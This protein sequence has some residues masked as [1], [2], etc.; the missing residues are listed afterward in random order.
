MRRGAHRVSRN[1]IIRVAEQIGREEHQRAEQEQEGER[2]PAVLG[3]EIGEE[4]HGIA[5]GLHFDPGGV[6]RARDMQRPDMQHD[7]ADDDEGQQIM[8]REEAVERSIIRREAAEQPLL[9]RLADQRNRAEQAGDDLGTPEAHLA[10]GQHIAHES[11]RHHQQEDDHAKQP[12]HL[13]RRLVGAEIEAAE[14]VDIDYHEEGRSAV[15]VG[16]AHQPAPVDVAHDVFDRI[17]SDPGIGGIMHRQ[18]DAGD[19]LHAQADQREKAEVP[20]IVDIARHRIARADGIIDQPRQRQLFVHPLHEG[21]ARLVF[22]GPGKAHDMTSEVS[23]PQPILTTVSDRNA[24]S[25]TS[26]FLG[27]GPLRIRAAVS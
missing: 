21:M 17:E 25:G 7:H 12:D 22:F 8:Q 14:N 13:A 19:D 11:G 27:A 5:L 16:I 9:D 26:R 23:W 24:N 10:P 18:H 2:R 3:D 6:G 20:P 15:G 1:V 4:R